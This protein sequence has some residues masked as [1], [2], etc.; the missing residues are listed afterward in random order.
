[1]FNITV[2][3]IITTKQKWRAKESAIKDVIIDQDQDILLLNKMLC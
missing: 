3:V 1:M 2:K